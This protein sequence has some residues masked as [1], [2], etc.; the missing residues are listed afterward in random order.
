M[1]VQIKN[2]FVS[3][4]RIPAAGLYRSQER[5]LIDFEEHSHLE[6]LVS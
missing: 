6:A 4:R 3:E 5:V 2:S 1:D